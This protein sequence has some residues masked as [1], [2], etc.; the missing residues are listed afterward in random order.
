MKKDKVLTQLL[1]IELRSN[2][3][4]LGF[5]DK[6]DLSISNNLLQEAISVL[7]Q[8]S[9]NSDE[10]SKKY[11]IAICALLWTYKKEKWDGLKDYLSLFLSRSGFGP[12]SIMIDKEYDSADSTFSKGSSL[13]NMFSITLSHLEH[14]ISISNKTFLLSEFQ[15]VYGMVSKKVKL[16]VFRLQLRQVNHFLYY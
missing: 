4:K 8:L 9:V 6:S 16:L 1:D 14:E 15:K 5:I 12:S 7:N 3:Y 13:I 11:L 2:A 10:Q